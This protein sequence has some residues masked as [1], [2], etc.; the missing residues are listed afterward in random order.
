MGG[1]RDPSFGNLEARA[2]KDKSVAADLSG[3]VK[4]ARLCPGAACYCAA[5][6][7]SSQRRTIRLLVTGADRLLRNPI[8]G[9]PGCCARAASGHATAAPPSSAMN[10]RR[11]TAQCLRASHERIAH[12]GVAG[13]RCGAGFQSAFD[14][15]GSSILVGSTRFNCWRHVRCPPIASGL[16]HRSEMTRRADF[17]L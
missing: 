6:F 3:D 4:S 9:I 14:R 12:L 7:Q 13:A 15:F 17:V 10:S 11:F 1:F 5:G 16:L 8:T 2:A